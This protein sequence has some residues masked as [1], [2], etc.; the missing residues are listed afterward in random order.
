MIAAIVAM[1][2]NRI[3]GANGKLPWHYSA[4]LKR[5]KDRTIG[6]NIIMGRLTWESIGCRALPKRRNIVIS[7]NSIS[8]VEVFSTIGTALSECDGDVWFI[9]GAM[10]YKS[11][12]SYCELIDVTYVPTQAVTGHVVYFPEL[13]HEEWKPGPILELQDDP[14]LRQQCY[15]RRSV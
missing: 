10:L 5:F 8:N 1:S 14:R 7:S 11:A 15:Y 4:D 9:G 13:R 6:S 2:S 3:I 12:L